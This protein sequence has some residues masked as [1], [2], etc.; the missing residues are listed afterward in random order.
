LDLR[1]VIR[2][3]DDMALQVPADRPWQASHAI[4]WDQITFKDFLKKHCW[5][6]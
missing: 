4:E 3:L 2:K 5:T 6:R 1:A